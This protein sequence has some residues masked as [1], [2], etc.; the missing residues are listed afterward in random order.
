VLRVNSLIVTLAMSFIVAGLASL[1]TGGNLVVLFDRL[2]FAAIART[3]M[4]GVRSSIW[5]MVIVIVLIGILLARTTTGRY[6]YAAGGN[7]EA[8][9]LA[10]VRVHWVRIFAFILSG[11]AAA[12]G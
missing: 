10:G 12:L 4:L 11:T 8:A 9:R 6:L 3:P 2:D 5:I 7:P 1:V